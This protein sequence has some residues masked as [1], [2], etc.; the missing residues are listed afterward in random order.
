MSQDEVSRL[1]ND[2]MSKPDM[3]TE[4]M[5][6]KDQEAMEAFIVSKGY[7]LTKDEMVDVWAMAAKVMGGR[8]APLSED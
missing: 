1:V 6:I 7:D 2:V 8:A 3:L 4:A 5:A